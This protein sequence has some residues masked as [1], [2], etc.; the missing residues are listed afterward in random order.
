MADIDGAM[1][2]EFAR[3]AAGGGFSEALT[4]ATR[5]LA[6][7]QSVSQALADAVGA[8]TQAVAQNTSSQGVKGAAADVGKSAASALKSLTLAPVFSSLFKVFGGGS[9]G[10]A[11]ALVKYSVPP[12]VSIEAA[13]LAQ[14]RTIVGA[15]LGQD[16]RARAVQPA[17]AQITVNVQAF[18][19]R[20][21]LDRSGDIAAAVREAM[22]N[23]HAINDVVSDL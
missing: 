8:N 9:K 6:G 10:E 23:S 19:S 17:G 13:Y 7:V 4:G 15:D 12:P 20:S 14:Q 2:E 3:V 18:D 11:P 22:L 21:F 16:G 5:Q 1:A